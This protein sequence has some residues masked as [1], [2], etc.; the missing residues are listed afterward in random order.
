M[1]S[2]P[3]KSVENDSPSSASESQLGE[4][5]QPD[6]AIAANICCSNCSTTKTP[7]WRRIDHKNYLCNACGLYFRIHGVQRPL[8]LKCDEYKPRKKYQKKAKT[9][10]RRLL[11]YAS[12]CFFLRRIS[13]VFCFL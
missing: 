2:S 7:L 13:F 8:H 11:F 6:A 4:E 3:V 10:V 12:N 9:L 1:A 5:K